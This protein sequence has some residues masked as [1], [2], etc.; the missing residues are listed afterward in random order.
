MERLVDICQ[1]LFFF[2]IGFRRHLQA[3]RDPDPDFVRNQLDRIFRSMRARAS[4]NVHLSSA[5]DQV[6]RP[7]VYLTDD[8]LINSEWSFAREWVEQGLEERKYDTHQG[9]ELYFDELE[10][11]QGEVAEILYMGLC[12]GFRGVFHDNPAELERKRGEYFYR[13]PIKRD[14]GKMFEKAYLAEKGALQQMKPL[15]TIAQTVIVCAGVIV[16]YFIVSHMLWEQSTRE[17]QD[18]ANSIANRSGWLP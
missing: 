13:F 16:F 12:L 11:A 2:L 17:L 7:L 18:V 3:G 6:E 9:G 15:M 5:Y 10:K 8:L 1:E 4:A 14:K